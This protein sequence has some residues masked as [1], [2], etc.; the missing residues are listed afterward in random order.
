MFVCVSSCV[1][2]CVYVCS[3]SSSSSSQKI[4]WIESVGD[5]FYDKVCVCV[6]V[7]VVRM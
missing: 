1:Y 4:D 2:I 3:S 6:C 5:N 7:C